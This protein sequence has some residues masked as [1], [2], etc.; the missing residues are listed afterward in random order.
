MSSRIIACVLFILFIFN[1]A[2]EVRQF[3]FQQ[4]FKI[5]FTLGLFSWSPTLLKTGGGMDDLPQSSPASWPG[6]IIN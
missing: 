4:I 2:T 3:I 1:Q 6:C 5:R